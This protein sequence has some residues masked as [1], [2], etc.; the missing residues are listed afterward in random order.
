MTIYNME[1][2]TR[3]AIDGPSRIEG[4]SPNRPARELTE[5]LEGKIVSPEVAA[6][7]FQ[8]DG[9][10]SPVEAAEAASTAIPIPSRYPIPGRAE[11]ASTGFPAA[12]GSG[13]RKGEETP[14][15]GKPGG[16]PYS[17]ADYRRLLKRKETLLAE[18]EEKA[19]R[20]RR[21]AEKARKAAR[22]LIREERIRKERWAELQDKHAAAY[23]AIAERHGRLIAVIRRRIEGL[24]NG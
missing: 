5:E 2:I 6:A 13:G 4:Y 9:G 14:D 8:A 12:G 15:G 18:A 21:W 24:S 3:L 11:A 20:Y 23:D 22:R 1:R 7:I 10:G 16:L 19:A 17:A